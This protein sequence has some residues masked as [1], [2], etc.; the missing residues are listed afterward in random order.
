MKLRHISKN[1]GITLVEILVV[2]GIFSV[3]VSLSFLFV[4]WKAVGYSAHDIKITALFLFEAR[5]R[6][7]KHVECTV[8]GKE[9]NVDLECAGKIVETEAYDS[10]QNEFEVVF[11]DGEVEEEYVIT[12]DEKN[13]VIP[14]YGAILW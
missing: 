5:D 6:S 8:V 10:Q 3:I 12:I 9:M 4:P 7:L 14:K 1:R 2:L 13:I 11:E